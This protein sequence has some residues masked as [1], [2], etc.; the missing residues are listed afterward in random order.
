MTVRGYP[1]EEP[2]DGN[3]FRG[4]FQLRLLI[5]DPPSVKYP[6]TVESSHGIRVSAGV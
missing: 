4:R 5:E 3:R 2:Q 6:N 1:P